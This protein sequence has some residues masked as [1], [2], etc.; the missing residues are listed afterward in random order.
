[1]VVVKKYPLIRQLT[2]EGI[3]FCV[4]KVD[5]FFVIDYYYQYLMNIYLHIKTSRG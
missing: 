5:I 2:D 1:V 3:S 4:N